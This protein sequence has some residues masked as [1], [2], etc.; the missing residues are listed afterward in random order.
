[1]KIYEVIEKLDTLFPKALS[2]SWDNDGC[3]LTLDKNAEI[4]GV[5]TTLDATDEAV[6]EAI[7]VGANLIVSH[8]PMIFKPISGLD[9]SALSK[10]IEKLIK[11]D[12][13]VLSYHTRF[14]SAEG[15]MNDRLA[16]KLELKNPE[17]FGLTGEIPMGRIGFWDECT[18]EEFAVKVSKLLDTDVVLY[19]G[20]RNIKKVAILGGG[21]KDF[22]HTAHTLGADAMVTGDISYG[23]VT[24]EMPYGITMVDAGHYPTEILATDAFAEILEEMGVQHVH[25]FYGKNPAKFIV[26]EN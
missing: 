17:P 14:D 13:S 6:E 15:G 12:I 2:E 16:R 19:S 10:K 23:I 22:I 4:K 21:G 8:H 1:M 20:K 9:G 26:K 3:M 5:L 25:R 18:P 24:D 7:R 11:N